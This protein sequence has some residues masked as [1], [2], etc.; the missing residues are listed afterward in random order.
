METVT[1]GSTPNE[2]NAPFGGGPRCTAKSKRSQ[3]QCRNAAMAGVTKCR[4]HG[5]KTEAR[6][7]EHSLT[8]GQH[9][10][11]VHQDKIKSVLSRARALDTPEGR[12]EAVKIGHALTTVR[13]EQVPQGEQFHDVYFRGA[14]T[15]LKHVETLHGLEVKEQAPTAPVINI[16]SADAMQHA[17]FEARTLEGHC[18]VRMLDGKPFVLDVATGGWMPAQ[19]RKDEESGAEIYERLL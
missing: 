18:T 15:A 5:G 13:L 11:W 14:N 19:L 17:P 1:D 6:P 16:L 9:S 8:H 12:A 10:P 4:M 2:N 7:M 3:V